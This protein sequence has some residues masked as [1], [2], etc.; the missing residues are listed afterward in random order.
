[1]SYEI[2]DLVIQSLELDPDLI[3]KRPIRGLPGITTR[4]LVDSLIHT[5]SISEAAT[6][7][8]YSDNPVKQAIRTILL[9]KFTDKTREFG[10][11]NNET[12]SWKFTLLS[13]VNMKSCSKCLTIKSI[14]EFS[15]TSTR[16]K[17]YID[18][19]CRVCRVIEAKKHKRYILDRTPEWSDLDKID[20]FYRN[21]PTGYHVDH[22]IPL[23]GKLV[24]G[25]HVLDNLQYLTAHDN[26]EKSNKYFF[27]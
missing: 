4:Q 17:K 15:Q 9:P 3:L 21:C 20:Q 27:S 2:T 1:M 22:I 26:L 5:N 18:T 8:G 23:R 6:A 13:A 7:L 25:L 16:N 24:S 19:L 12:T 10:G 11:K 14:F